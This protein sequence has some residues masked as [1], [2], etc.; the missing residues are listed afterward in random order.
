MLLPNSPGALLDAIDRLYA[1]ALDPAEWRGFL[2]AMAAV[3]GADNAYVSRIRH[4]HRTLDYVV[5]HDP[6]WDAVSVGRYAALMDEDPRMP[7]FRGNP[8]R[9]VHCRMV[10]PQERLHASRTYNEALKPLDIEYTMVVGLPESPGVTRYLGVTRARS[11]DP[12]DATECE[13]LGELVPHLRRVFAIRHVLERQSQQQVTAR[14]ILERLPFGVMIV[15]LAGAV[16]DMNAAAHQ[17]LTAGRGLHLVNGRV[18]AKRDVDNDKLLLALSAD[19]ATRGPQP[20][21]LRSS[22]SEAPLA[23]MVHALA[24]GTFGLA[25]AAA[26]DGLALI[27]IACPPQRP[28]AGD[29]LMRQLF[30]LTPA[31]ARVTALLVSGHSLKEAAATLGITE[32]TARQYL[33]IVFQKTG[34][35][36]QAD[37]VRVISNVLMLQI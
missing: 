21:L 26:D 17:L 13:L 35:R 9:P 5:L 11:G 28:Q 32:G 23:M 19:H 16:I 4:D 14:W 8:C 12:F 1:A 29:D 15:N 25:D 10:V 31:Q 6:N 20:V 36:R 27:S 22:G 33:K 34:T 37:L 18:R 7:A 30:G 2:A 3:L 24:P